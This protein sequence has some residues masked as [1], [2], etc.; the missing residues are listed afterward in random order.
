MAANAM[1]Y[2][3]L[4]DPERF[5]DGTRSWGDISVAAGDQIVFGQDLDKAVDIAMRLARPDEQYS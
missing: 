2:E 4:R 3:W 1:R 5:I